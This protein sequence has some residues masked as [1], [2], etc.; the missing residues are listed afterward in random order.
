M[1]MLLIIRWCSF[2]SLI[3]L[4]EFLLKCGL[5]SLPWLSR[6]GWP[7]SSLG[8]LDGIRESQNH[9]DWQLPWHL[10][11]GTIYPFVL[12]WFSMRALQMCEGSCPVP[13]LYFSGAGIPHKLCCIVERHFL[14]SEACVYSFHHSPYDAVLGALTILDTLVSLLW[15]A[16]AVYQVSTTVGTEGLCWY[17]AQRESASISSLEVTCSPCSAVGSHGLVQTATW[18]VCWGM[19][20]A[21]VGP[22]LADRYL[23]LSLSL[24][25]SC[26]A[27]PAAQSGFSSL[28]VVSRF[29][30]SLPACAAVSKDLWGHSSQFTATLW[31]TSQ[32][33][34]FPANTFLLGG[35]TGQ[36]FSPGWP[37]AGIY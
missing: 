17:P 21:W 26:P 32:E 3:Q 6:S 29:V 10:H 18:S 25:A 31:P 4:V 19:G 35:R 37:P 23:T 8:R 2:L 22:L 20:A 28:D 36:W 11:P 33:L 34:H 27:H 7:L 5:Q 16:D 14:F 15:S 24:Y 1:T 12:I 13:H 9:L 30:M